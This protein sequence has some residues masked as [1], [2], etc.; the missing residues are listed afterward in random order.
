[1]QPEKVISGIALGFDI[2]LAEAAIYLKIPLVAYIPYK[3]QGD[4]WPIQSR[5]R[6]SRI[7]EQADSIKIFSET[8]KKECFMIRNKAMV[9][10]SE[11]IL[12][13]LNTQ[14]IYTGTFSTVKYAA[15]KDK[16]IVNLWKK[17]P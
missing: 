15:S 16:F 2:W 7:L 3:G 13:L 4:N 17:L 8:Y 11:I 6:R 9:D 14:S 10:D 1:M 5:N 12:A